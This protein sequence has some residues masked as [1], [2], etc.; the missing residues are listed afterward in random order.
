MEMTITFGE[1]KKVLAEY[2]HFTVVTDQ[3]H[4]AGGDDAA[5]SPF[6]L[7]LTSI[8]TCVGY[9]VLMFCRQRNISAEDI[10]IIQRT[11]Q[12]PATHLISKIDIDIKLPAE[13]PDKYHDAVIKAAAQCTVKRHLQVPP[14]FEI[15]T[16]VHELIES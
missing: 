5:P 13:F 16:S 12:D 14:L 6:D 8:G 4:H 11:H 9:Y 3:P 1:N 7:F 10:R 2:K 15:K